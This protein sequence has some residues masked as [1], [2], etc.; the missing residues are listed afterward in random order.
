MIVMKAAEAESMLHPYYEVITRVV[1]GAWADW[2][3]NPFASQMQHKRVRATCMW[4]QL[5]SRAKRE[6]AD[7]G[8]VE[9]VTM[10][11]WVGLLFNN[12][13]FVRFK[14]GTS[15]LFS[16]NYP[17]SL[18]MAFHDQEQDLFDGV[19]RLE[20]V[21][22]LDDAEAEIDRIAI[23]RRHKRS[24]D[25]VLDLKGGSHD[26]QAPLPFAPKAPAGG[27]D[28]AARVLKPRRRPGN[29]ESK[30]GAAGE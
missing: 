1:E 29:D 28:I 19:R 5:I 9:V 15:E 4:N 13:V 16:S 8:G 10:H 6:F 2:M 25:W 24:I 26:T 23:I 22:V 12:A 21:Y 27:A 18:A 11:E 30:R 7:L 17:T 20:L 3:T 14:K